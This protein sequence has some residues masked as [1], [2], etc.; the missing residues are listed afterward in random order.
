MKLEH[1][2]ADPILDEEVERYE[3]FR[4]QSG[5]PEMYWYGQQDDYNVMIFEL[6]G[7]SLE[8]L[9]AFCGRQFS[10]KTCLMIIDQLLLRLE[11]LHSKGLLHRDIKPQNILLGSGTNGNTVYMTD[12][13]LSRE[14]KANMDGTKHQTLT[15]CRLVGTTRYASI[16]GHSGQGAYDDRCKKYLILIISLVQSQKD[17]LE[18]LGYMMI[19]LVQGKLPWQGLRAANSVEKDLLVMKKKIALSTSALCAGLP[20]EFAEYMRYVKSLKQGEK[21]DYAMLR[22][23]FRGLAQRHGIEYDNVFDWTLRVYLQE[24]QNHRAR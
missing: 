14:Y 12:F 17:D 21:P 3:S 7:P 4:G 2:L 19:Y 24:E 23:M 22:K 20:Q 16:R 10:I 18:S 6:L 9:F 8:D 11:V 13:G 1:R 15:R 5:F